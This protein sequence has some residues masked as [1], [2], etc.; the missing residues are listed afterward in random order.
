[1]NQDINNE[2]NQLKTIAKKHNLLYNNFINNYDK[3]KK[4]KTE[5]DQVIYELDDFIKEIQKFSKNIK[6]INSFIYL[7]AIRQKWTVIYSSI[8]NKPKDIVINFIK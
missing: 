8:L 3:L 5:L 1:M 7:N 6:D 2:I 4:N